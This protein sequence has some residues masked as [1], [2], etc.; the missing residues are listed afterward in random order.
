MSNLTID[1]PQDEEHRRALKA[2]LL[3]KDAQIRDAVIEIM[4]GFD[5][6]T[7]DGMKES[8]KM[9]KEAVESEIQSFINTDIDFNVLIT[10]WVIQ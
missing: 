10:E 9:A 1:S 8:R 2:L 5:L 4:I 6:K 7:L 3:E